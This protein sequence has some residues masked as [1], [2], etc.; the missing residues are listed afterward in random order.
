MA[1]VPDAQAETTVRAPA[2]G[3]EAHADG[4]C[5]SVR[6][7]HGNRHGE[8][9]TWAF[10]LQHVPRVEQSPET[11]DAS[12]IVNKNAL[13]GHVGRA[14]VGP[15]LAS[16]DESELGRGVEAFDL[17][18]LEYLFGPYFCFGRERDRQFV[19]VDPFVLERAGS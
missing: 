9:P 11:A 17:L 12:R 15:G 14:G 2:R 16:G 10:L 3:P 4:G 8:N 13:G 19:A 18:A 1:S 6:H 5:S 7:E